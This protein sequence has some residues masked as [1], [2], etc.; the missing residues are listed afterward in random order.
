MKTK[1][2]EKRNITPKNAVEILKKNG[3]EISEEKAIK[4]LDT[5]YFL[6]ELVIEQNFKKPNK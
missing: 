4:I 2:N 6:S 5:L 1:L 3:V